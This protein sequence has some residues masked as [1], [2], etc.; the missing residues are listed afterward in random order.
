MV[1]RSLSSLGFTWTRKSL[2]IHSLPIFWDLGV[3]WLNP[4]QDGFHHSL[5]ICISSW[6]WSLFWLQEEGD[7]SC[8]Y[9]YDG[10]E[11]LSEWKEQVIYFPQ[12]PLY[13][14]DDCWENSWGWKVTEVSSWEAWRSSG[15][16]VLLW[17]PC[18]QGQCW[19]ERHFSHPPG[20]QH[21]SGS[22]RTSGFGLLERVALYEH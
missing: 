16:L 10:K 18:D 6:H 22:L 1:D 13:S 12:D 19:A 7:Y 21:S 9:F 11:K 2:K 14:V 20:N 15:S 4:D 17:G 5:S 3:G 8:F